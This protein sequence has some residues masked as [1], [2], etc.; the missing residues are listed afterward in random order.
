MDRKLEKKFWTT[1]RVVSTVVTLGIAG[2]LGYMVLST[3]GGTRL[4]VDPNRISVS[5]V[6]VG[7]FREY[8]PTIGTVEPI[9]T[10]FLDVTQGGRVEEIFVDDGQMLIKGQPIL[11][12]SNDSFTLGAMSNET[13]GLETISQLRNDRIRVTQAE[14]NL[15]ENLLDKNY[16][17]LL[18][19]KRMARLQGIV[20]KSGDLISR[21]EFEDATDELEYQLASRELLLERIA[22]DRVLNRQQLKDLEESLLRAERNQQLISES[23]KSLLVVA[24]ISGQ[25]STLAAEEGRN[26]RQGENIGQIDILDS[27]K[28][29]ADID[30]FYISKVEVGQDGN[31]TFNAKQYLLRVSK[32]Y[33]EV[34]NG[35]F[36]IDFEFA[37]EMAI[38]IRPGQS[39]Q[40]NL[41]LSGLQTSVLVD[42]G[43]FYRDTGGRWIYRV[44]EDGLS[45]Y[46]QEIRLGRQNPQD[47][48]VLE[49]LVEGDLVITSSYSTYNDVDELI[50][51]EP[52]IGR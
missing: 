41:S 16:K 1:N 11:R 47:Y 23:L 38:G 2:L 15:K 6:R 21:K 33:P 27:F 51:S 18:L 42:Q 29:T 40:I 37:Q 26:I 31:F 25:L 20:D 52:V 19:E 8:T 50:F 24:P 43:G 12:L 45:A 35:V 48:E 14:L 9:R 13:R 3:S 32:I 44:S 34:K 22:Q 28:V 4:R 10:V 7:E 17:I 36:A 39:L 46:R 49:G 5:T 30:E